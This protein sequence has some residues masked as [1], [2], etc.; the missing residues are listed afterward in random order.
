M[1]QEN[2]KEWDSAV[3]PSPAVVG[4]CET[5]MSSEIVPGNHPTEW[6]DGIGKPTAIR[7][8]QSTVSMRHGRWWL[9]T[10]PGRTVFIHHRVSIQ[11]LIALASLMVVG[12][13]RD[14]ACEMVKRGH[15]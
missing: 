10:I 3:Q 6:A 13:R 14:C 12:N 4:W 2:H 7:W 5:T 11:W 15:S 8:F 9:K 1:V